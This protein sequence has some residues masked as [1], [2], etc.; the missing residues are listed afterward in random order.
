MLEVTKRENRPEAGGAGVQSE[1]PA[2]AILREWGTP[3]PRPLQGA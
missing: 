1:M 3:P 2:A